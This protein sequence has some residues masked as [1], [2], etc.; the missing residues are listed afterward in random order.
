MFLCTGDDVRDLIAQEVIQFKPTHRGVRNSLTK[1]I[2]NNNA[3][4]KF[5]KQSYQEKQA[6]AQFT[7]AQQNSS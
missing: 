4:I 7:S 2:V 5:F 1:M 3:R 6:H